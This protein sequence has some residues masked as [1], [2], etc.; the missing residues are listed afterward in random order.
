MI[1]APL[2]MDKNIPNIENYKQNFNF[3]TEIYEVM[4]SFENNPSKLGP[5]INELKTKFEKARALLENIP[6]IDMSLSEQQEYYQNLLNQYKKEN[7]LLNSYKEMCTFDLSKL[8]Q[9]P[10]Q[11]STKT[12]AQ[13]N[14]YQDQNSLNLNQQSFQNIFNSDLNLDD[15]N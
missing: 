1:Y 10:D 7:E 11:C 8:D 12:E 13:E 6:G 4:K 15:L 5:K 3:L 9:N 2:R 14:F